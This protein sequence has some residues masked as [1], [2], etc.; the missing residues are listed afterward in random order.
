[1]DVRELRLV[2]TVDDYD[3][4]LTFY[5]DVLGLDQQAAYDAPNGG[6][7]TLLDA[8]RATVELATLDARRTQAARCEPGTHRGYD[9]PRRG[10]SAMPLD[11][12]RLWR[13]GSSRAEQFA[14]VD[15]CDHA[16]AARA[17]A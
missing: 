8:G 17:H 6:R 3:A 9:H 12:L 16:P 15:L 11:H 13:Q 1:M 5:R 7:V 2:L 14:T 10:G 4:A